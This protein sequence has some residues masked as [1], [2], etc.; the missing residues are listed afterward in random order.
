MVHS[1]FNFHSNKNMD[2]FGKFIYL[3]LQKTGSTYI[4]NF[5]IKFSSCNR[6]E[7]NKH[8][9]I[10]SVRLNS[11]Y[12]ISIR[13]PL[14]WYKSLFRY[15]LTRRGAVHAK[16]LKAG[17]EYLYSND[18]FDEWMRFILDP[19]NSPLLAEFYSKTNSTLF[20]FLT[21]RFMCLSVESPYLNLANVH[22]QDDLK[23]LYENKKIHSF[24]IK[25][26]DMRDDL[27]KLIMG[28]KM[29]STMLF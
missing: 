9:P 6:I 22:T 20:G 21:Y 14:D 23:K 17:L 10:K 29:H 16:L 2:D 7:L 8:I 28:A 26:E 19:K 18:K 13:N 27:K 3:D 24:I 5:F 12:I 1:K 25:Q 15:G 11:L 4:S